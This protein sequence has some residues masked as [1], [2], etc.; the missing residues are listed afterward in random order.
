MMASAMPPLAVVTGAAAGIGRAA[1]DLLVRDG[2]TVVA[3]DSN[4]DQ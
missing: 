1:V 2:W 3:L 4:G